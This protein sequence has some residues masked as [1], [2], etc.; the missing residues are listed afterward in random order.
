MPVSASYRPAPRH[1]ALGDELYD[2]V[3]PA[4]FPRRELRFRNQRWA[5]RIG[6]ETLDASEWEAHF[7]RFEPLPGNLPTPLALRY[8][9][10]QFDVYNPHLGDGR[11]F[12][13]AQLLDDTGRLLD[14]GT[15]GS[16]TTP[17]SRGGDGRLTLK[18]GVREV[19]A[20][21][22]LEALGVPTSKSL[23]LFETGEALMRGDEPSPT[24]SSV[25]VR[26][27]HSHVRFGTF[28]RLAHRSDVAGLELLLSYAV[29]NY[30]PAIGDGP[31]RPARFLAEVTR[32]S[33][34]LCAA[35]MVAGFVH[36]VLNSDNLAV[37]GEGFDYGPY[38]F[39]PTYDVDFVAAYF[40]HQGLY[41]FGHQPR[42]FLRNL[43]RLGEAL[44][45]LSP[46]I[47]LA[48]ALASFE[49]TLEQEVTARTIARLG[50]T[51]GGDADPALVAAV[52]AFLEET[53]VG[54][55]RFFFD[56]HGG[57]VE[58]RPRP[59]R[60]T[61]DTYTGARWDELRAV[62][63]LYE[64]AHDPTSYFER[65]RPCTLL[66]DEIESI[67]DAIARDDDWSPFEAKVRDIRTMGAAL[68]GQVTTSS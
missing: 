47:A 18:G 66:I 65:D 63:S 14:L 45:P 20:T 28:Q 50:L 29:A 34:S 31:D 25:L 62:L 64:P 1:T 35:F 60:D 67:W 27:S 21:E 19:L 11:G 51:P 15:K 38:R 54:Y 2:E 42:A 5:E 24:R 22:M 4:R 44:R 39:L 41:A 68:Q 12:L 43:V 7:A 33:A 17:W 3:A 48:P 6:L 56:L 30:Y 57:L 53:D 9:G 46:D 16:G 52:Y 40:D 55:D 32:A 37:T 8:H 36:G 61:K 49:V 23:S 10:H 13:F 59:G 58:G 26:L